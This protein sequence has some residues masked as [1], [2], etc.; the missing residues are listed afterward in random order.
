MKTNFRAQPMSVENIRQMAK[1]IRKRFGL[2]SVLNVPVCYFFEWILGTFCSDFEWEIIPDED[3]R[4]EGVTFTAANK[5]V[6]R[7]SV[8]ESACRGDGRARFTI[9][10]EIG[11]LILHGPNR[12][13]LCRLAS[14]EQLKAYEDPEW[15]ADTFASEFLMDYDLIQGMDY[16]QI[17][18]AC[19]VSFGAAKTRIGKLQRRKMR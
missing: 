2:T 5:I 18:D 4:E 7:E 3:M 19:G 6:I 1:D 17:S 12:V 8:Y 15:Q 9:M 13:A 11:H 16:R 10:H 14:G